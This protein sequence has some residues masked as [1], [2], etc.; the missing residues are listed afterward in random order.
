MDIK[1]LLIIATEIAVIVL[2]VTTL[3][4]NR[5]V[6]KNKV[7]FTIIFGVFV[8]A[9]TFATIVLL[10]V[11]G[12]F[13]PSPTLTEKSLVQDPSSEALSILLTRED[14][15]NNWKWE[16]IETHQPSN[17]PWI[18]SKVIESANLFFAAKVPHLLIFK[19]Y[20]RVEHIVQYFASPFSELEFNKQIPMK[21]KVDTAFALNLNQKGKYFYTTC[22]MGSDYYSCDVSIGYDY[23]ISS[24]WIMTP[25]EL[26]K[27]YMID[28]LNSAIELTDQRIQK[29]TQ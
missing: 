20:V 10:I 9:Q 2:L 21:G 22:V 3:R 13:E 8:S 25:E 7:L 5:F 4:K 19:H 1:V 12:A 16:T 15:P 18:D 23:I 28:L 24:I 29:I 14:M 11:A 6:E 26:G 27:Q 17:L